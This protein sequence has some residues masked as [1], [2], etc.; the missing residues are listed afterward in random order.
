[1]Q[2]RIEISTAV[3]DDRDAEIGVARLKK[4]GQDNATGSNA[5]ENE[6]AN[7]V[8][9]ENHR[10]VG[11]GESADTVLYDDDFVF[12][13]SERRVDVAQWF[14]KQAL[15]LRRSLDCAQ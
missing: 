14:L 7:V 1:M 15:M 10:E 9:A 2:I 3:L 11:T 12:C 5:E 4:S 8:C 6:R 13:G